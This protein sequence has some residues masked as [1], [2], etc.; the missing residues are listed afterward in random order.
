MACAS[1]E[2]RDVR[3][4]SRRAGQ[5]VRKSDAEGFREQVVLG[6]QNR[7][8]YAALLG[9]QEARARWSESLSTPQAVSA[10]ALIFVTEEQPVRVV[11]SAEGWVFAEDPTRL[12]DQSSPRAALRSLVR[13]SRTAR[14]D[15][16]LGLAPERYRV[17]LSEDKLRVAWTEGEYS[18]DLK[19]RRDLLADHLAD[20]IIADAHMATLAL[21]DGHFALL[22]RERHRWVVVDF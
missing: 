15:V 11:E 16:L 14:W 12:Y 3:D 7:V 8:N 6:A 21:G 18:K 2:A 20:P 10:E 13:A 17:D 19:Q 5:L 22:E 9:D 4:A 1:S